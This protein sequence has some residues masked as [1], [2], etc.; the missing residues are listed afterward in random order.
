MGLTASVKKLFW[1]ENAGHNIPTKEPQKLQRIII[2]D[3]LKK[4]ED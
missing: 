4:S 3:I 1:F 2:D